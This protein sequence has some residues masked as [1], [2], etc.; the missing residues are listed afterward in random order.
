MM[1]PRGFQGEKNKECKELEHA[2]RRIY[3]WEL[4]KVKKLRNDG[5]KLQI[6]NKKVKDKNLK[7]EE[8]TEKMM[9][10]AFCVQR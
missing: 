3:A 6:V 10:T 7:I 9:R 4:L 8:E 1:G 5:T 2:Q